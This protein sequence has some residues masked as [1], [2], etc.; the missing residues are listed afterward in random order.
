MMAGY[1]ARYVLTSGDR[2]PQTRATMWPAPT[3]GRLM[4]EFRR[5]LATGNCA[6]CAPVARAEGWRSAPG[7]VRF[8]HRDPARRTEQDTL[9]SPLIHGGD[10][11]AFFAADVGLAARAARERLRPDR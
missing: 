11:P 7:S 3:G 5:R 2:I 8:E 1:S 9:A 4:I 10:L 6:R